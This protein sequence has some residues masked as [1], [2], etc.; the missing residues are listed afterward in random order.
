MKSPK[1]LTRDLNVVFAQLDS[2]IERCNTSE[3]IQRTIELAK[4]IPDLDPWNYWE[5][6]LAT[7]A[8]SHI[9]QRARQNPLRRP[10]Q[11]ELDLSTLTYDS[12]KY[13][14]IRLG[15]GDFVTW[16]KST[17]RDL[18]IHVDT[19]IRAGQASMDCAA[20]TSALIQSKVGE[21][22]QRN[23]GMTLTEAMRA[24]GLWE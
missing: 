20:L 3:Y 9:E 14:V 7:A 21:L 10:D 22:M 16:A 8:H 24:A 23:Y 17:L 1:Q 15:N 19:Q 11:L 13:P 18:Q 4:S 12:V 6:L 5:G 2:E